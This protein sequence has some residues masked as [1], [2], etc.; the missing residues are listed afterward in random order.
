MARDELGNRRG[1]M[2]LAERY[3]AGEAQRAARLDR[4]S[5]RGLLR[6]LDIGQQLYAALVENAT[7]LRQAQ[8][9]RRAIEQAGV[10]VRF[11]LGDLA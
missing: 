9:A 3:G 6:L 2:A 11:E 7:A 1:K 5:M 10:Q 4:A 8:S